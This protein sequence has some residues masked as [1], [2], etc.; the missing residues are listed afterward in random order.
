MPIVRVRL[1]IRYKDKVEY[2][3]VYYA[4][5]VVREYLEK[6]E[7]KDV[8]QFF[9]LALKAAEEAQKRVI[10]KYGFKCWGTV[11]LIDLLNE[12]KKKEI[13]SIKVI[14]IE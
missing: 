14:E 10:E 5:T 4:S 7:Y 6:K 9:K 1:E 13:V 2:H 8:E 3:E 12:L 11:E